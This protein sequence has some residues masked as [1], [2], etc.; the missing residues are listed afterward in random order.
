MKYITV[1]SQSIMRMWMHHRDTTGT[2]KNLKQGHCEWETQRNQ[3]QRVR[4]Y[5]SQ[6]LCLF[7]ITGSIWNIVSL[8]IIKAAHLS[9]TFF[10]LHS[11]ITTQLP[12][13]S[14]Q[15]KGH[16]WLPLWEVQEDEPKILK[17]WIFFFNL[18]E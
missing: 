15:R 13:A 4:D 14:K 9:I 1:F 11:I 8:N 2:E 12:Q 6:S 10:F 3:V 16:R 7:G 18:K 5:V 17:S